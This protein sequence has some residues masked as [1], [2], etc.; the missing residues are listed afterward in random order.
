M[1]WKEFQDGTHYHMIW[2]TKLYLGV[3]DAPKPWGLLS[4]D[5]E[6]PGHADALGR[7]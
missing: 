1:T 4:V 3:G 6:S 2:V 7:L 5:V